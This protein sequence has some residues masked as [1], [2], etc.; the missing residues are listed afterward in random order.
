LPAKREEFSASEYLSPSERLNVSDIPRL[1]VPAGGGTVWELPDGSAKKSLEI[2]IIARRINRVYY[3]TPYAGENTQPDCVSRDGVI[4][5]GNPGG[6]CASCPLSKFSGKQVPA[7]KL[8][9]LLYAIERES[10]SPVILQLPPSSAA[11]VRKYLV[12]NLLLTRTNPASVWTVATLEKRQ[13]PQGISYSAVALKRGEAVSEAEA[14]E[15]AAMR[16]VLREMA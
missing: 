10:L 4:G 3:A 6:E 11:E 5:E 12:Q 2:C 15:I 9:T 7:C 13:N 8:V 14:A 1:K 16:D